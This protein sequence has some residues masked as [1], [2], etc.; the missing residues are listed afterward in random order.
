MLKF[1]NS[2]KKQTKTH[3]IYNNQDNDV[4]DENKEAAD[5]DGEHEG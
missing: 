5:D 4:N 1:W 3:E 2:E